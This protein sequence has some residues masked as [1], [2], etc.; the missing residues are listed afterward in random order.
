MNEL[1]IGSELRNALC[2][3]PVYN[4]NMA[5]KPIKKYNKNYF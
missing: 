2:I 1:M 3:K 5:E 4:E